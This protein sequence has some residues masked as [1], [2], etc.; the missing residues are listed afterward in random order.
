VAEKRLRTIYEATELGAGFS[1][2]MK[3]LEI[4]GAG[5]LLGMRQSGQISAVGFNLYSQMLASAVEKLKLQKNGIR[6]TPTT[7]KLPDPTIDLPLSALITED[8]VP[9]LVTRLELYQRM[10]DIIELKQIP[11]LIQEL[12]DRF[13]IPPK[14]VENLFYILKIKAMAKD[15]GIEAIS[16]LDSEII[17][18]LFTGMQFNKQ[19]LAHFLREGI[20]IGNSQL[21]MNLRQPGK[22]WQKV[23]EEILGEMK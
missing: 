17:L 12:N 1:I 10:A 22:G 11:N 9:D 3:D 4:R 18:Q 21:R 15:T 19:K 5:T 13:G 7:T 16:T 8:Y 14:E 20:K 2:A 6:Q 23:L